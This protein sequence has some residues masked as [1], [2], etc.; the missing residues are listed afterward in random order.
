LVD[1]CVTSNHIHLLVWAQS[2][3]CI[4]RFMQELQGHFALHYN[5]RKHRSG[6]FWEERYHATMVEGGEHLMNCPVYIDLNMV[7]AG[8]VWHPEQWRWCG[9]HEL[10]GGRQRYC[11]LDIEALLWVLAISGRDAL[12]ELHRA[13]IAEAIEEKRLCREGMWT[14]SIAIGSESFV[15]SI[16]NR[17]RRR[18]RLKM[19]LASQG[20]CYIQEQLEPYGCQ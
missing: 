16:A 11:I 13:A 20:A 4:S 9:Y 10:I 6:A 14:E 5:R 15:R 17:T 1:F 3:A 19:V 8:V 2:T 18:R 7:R 12:A